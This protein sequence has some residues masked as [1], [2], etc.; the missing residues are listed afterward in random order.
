M[1]ISASIER[2]GHLMREMGAWEHAE[3]TATDR[4]TGIAYHNRSE[5]Y[6]IAATALKA[7]IEQKLLELLT[8][9][10]SDK[11]AKLRQQFY[12]GKMTGTEF[13]EQLVTIITNK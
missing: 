2:Y 1:N 12:D 13:V 11:V 5:R 4:T 10:D 6:R 3:Q 9:V 7:D 8:A